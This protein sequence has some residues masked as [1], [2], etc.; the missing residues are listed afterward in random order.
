MS[1]IRLLSVDRSF[2]G[3][4]SEIGRYRM[5]PENKLPIFGCERAPELTICVGR[6]KSSVPTNM[7]WWK[8]LLCMFEFKAANSMRK[9]A[10]SMRGSEKDRRVSG[11][12]EQAELVLQQLS[13]VRNDLTDT[14][15]D[16]VSSGKR[17]FVLDIHR[18]PKGAIQEGATAS[19][20]GRWTR[21]TGK[22]FM[23]GRAQAE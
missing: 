5:K 17:P 11:G 23:T 14:D 8:R 16:V 2:I 21:M 12:L 10:P 19:R 13:V 18:S 9:N 3:S 4:G 6:P 22:L 20:G 15:V 7:S 1:F